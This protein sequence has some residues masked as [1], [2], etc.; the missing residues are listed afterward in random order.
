[1]KK[2]IAA[3]ALLSCSFIGS[4]NAERMQ[5]QYV[6][7]NK[8]GSQLFVASPNNLN[9]TQFA[10]VIAIGQNPC[11]PCGPKVAT[12]AFTPTCVSAPCDMPAPCPVLCDPCNMA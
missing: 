11:N 1:M 4:V 7:I 2:L 6:A 12:I 9:T 5:T 10:S 3:M 8:C